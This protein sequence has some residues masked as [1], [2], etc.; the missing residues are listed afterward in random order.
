MEHEIDSLTV[1][2]ASAVMRPLYCVVKRELRWFGH[3]IKMPPDCKSDY[4]NMGCSKCAFKT[5]FQPCIHTALR[6]HSL[7]GQ[8]TSSSLW[9]KALEVKKRKLLD[10]KLYKN[11]IYFNWMSTEHKITEKVLF[12]WWDIL[13]FFHPPTVGCCEML[14]QHSVFEGCATTTV[15]V[16]YWFDLGGERGGGRMRKVSK[17]RWRRAQLWCTQTVGPVTGGC[18][19]LLWS[20]KFVLKFSALKFFK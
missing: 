20:T 16:W 15:Y 8:N 4:R 7:R 9:L 5:L 18:A 13:V 2:A 12:F 19:S 3:L 14:T 10:W 17:R 1:S 11:C 6:G